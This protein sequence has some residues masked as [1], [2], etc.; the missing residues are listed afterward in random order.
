MRKS[1]LYLSFNFLPAPLFFRSPSVTITIGDM[2][3]YARTLYKTTN[4]IICVQTCV[5]FSN[6]SEP[7]CVRIRVVV[8]EKV[9]RAKARLG[10]V[11]TES[12]SAV[13]RPPTVVP[14]GSITS[15]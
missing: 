3:F 2:L 4:V 6:E 13:A 10:A 5:L 8:L 14:V 9:R 7:Y 1:S 11:H 12:A 15:A